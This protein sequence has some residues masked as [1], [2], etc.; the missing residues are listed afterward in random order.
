[1][2]PLVIYLP[3]GYEGQGP[4]H[5]S[6]R[7]ER[8]LILSA[9]NNMQIAN[10]TTPA[11]FFHIL[12]R[13]LKRDFRKPLIIF[14]PKSL[15]RHPKTIS[16]IKDFTSGGFKEVIDDVTAKPDLVNKIVFCTGKLYYDLLAEKEKLN[17]NTITLVRLE[18]LHPFPTVQVEKIRKKYK[19]A[20]TI[21]WTQEEPANM[22]AW[23]FIRNHMPADFKIK[24]ICRPASGSTATG[25]PKFHV[26]RQQKILDKVFEECDCPYIDQECNMACIGNKWKS[27]E[28][29]LKELQVDNIN[30]KF[31][32][33]TK[34]LKN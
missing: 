21:I 10:C 34:P 27:F 30:S 7:M 16:P 24:S 1:M 26:I 25:S 13:Q 22:G 17:N 33:G 31:H 15:L 32:S 9:E 6:A 2:S 3:H 5:S 8:F 12:R 29:E 14:T 28:K 18:Q 20:K 19:L 4:E 23:E 11:N